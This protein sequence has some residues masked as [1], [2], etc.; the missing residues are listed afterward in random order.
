MLIVALI[1]VAIGLLLGLTG[2]GGS[3]LA[4]PLL[5][6]AAG[7]EHREAQGLA[8]AAVAAAAAAGAFSRWRAGALPLRPALVFAL[9]GVPAALAGVMLAEQLPAATMRS[10]FAVL[11]LAVAARMGWQL[12]AQPLA[13]I[14]LRAGTADIPPAPARC[15]I[16][17]G[18]EMMLGRA[19]LRVL[20]VAGAAAGFAAGLFGVGAGFLVVP[21]LVLVAGFPPDRAVAASLLIITLLAGAAFLFQQ[22]LGTPV[23]LELLP[24]VLAGALAGMVLARSVAPRLG[25]IG[26]Q[27][28]F[29]VLI[30]ITACY[31]LFTTLA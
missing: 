29:I 11:M 15:P 28:L 22:T 26:M 7:L 4:V 23:T 3:V 20:V 16:Q 12:Q 1:G 17:P 6:L 21:A 25:G 27:W 9:A 18:G 10:L 8:L 14:A 5:I 31:L 30:C 19:C 24:V 2:A 13:A